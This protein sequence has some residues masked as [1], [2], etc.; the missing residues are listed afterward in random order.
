MDL[1]GICKRYGLGR[2]ETGSGSRVTKNNGSV[3][4]M[5][6][7][8]NSKKKKTLSETTGGLITLYIMYVPGTNTRMSRDDC[9]NNN[10]V[11]LSSGLG[12]SKAL[13]TAVLL[14]L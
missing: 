9:R 2:S 10:N 12:L 1:Y 6:E 3:R 5:S 8:T 13:K 14:Q 11:S 7:N 4:K